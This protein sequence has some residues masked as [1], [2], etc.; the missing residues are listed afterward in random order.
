MRQVLVSD[1]FSSRDLAAR[2]RD[3]LSVGKG[4][5]S[6]GKWWVSSG[7]FERSAGCAVYEGSRQEVEGDN[8]Q[9]AG[10]SGFL[11]LVG[12]R[13]RFPVDGG[14]R[15]RKPG[16]NAA[17]FL[18]LPALVALDAVYRWRNKP[19]GWTRLI[20]STKGGQFFFILVGVIGVCCSRS[21]Q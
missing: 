15:W 10:W 11:C 12:S 14:Y 13:H 17:F 7:R 21:Y 3:L 18:T 8:F 4:G 9:C 20:S 2:G 5:G 19:A 6:Y 1:T 16:F